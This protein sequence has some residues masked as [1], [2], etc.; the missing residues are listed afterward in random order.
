M[1][2]KKPRFDLSSSTL[3]LL[4]MFFMLLDHMW[5]TVV[6]GNLWMTVVGRIA[7]PI[8]AFLLVEGFS[9]THDVRKYLGRLL[10]FAVIS[11]IPFDLMAAGTVFSPFHQNV[12]WTFAIALLGMWGVE[13]ARKKESLWESVLLS[14]LIVA[15]TVLLGF[16]CFTDYYG[17]GVMTVYI[18]YF[19]RGREW[20][21]RLLQFLLLFYLNQVV[22]GGRC[23]PVAIGNFTLEIA[24]QT[25]AL[26]ALIPIWLYKGRKG[27][28][29]K[30]FQYACY[31]FYP[32]HC[33]ALA[34]IAM[35]M[36]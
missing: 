32:A 26:F 10:L 14:A 6:T 4:A 25:F 36:G 33:L 22:M 12:L 35:F 2:D 7:F 8:F 11:E 24:E 1:E 9:H 13:T 30:A 3:H 23:F 21:K 27:I 28:R 19:F 15:G 31:A 29:A 17:F 5:A 18:F 16:I 20:W 34:L